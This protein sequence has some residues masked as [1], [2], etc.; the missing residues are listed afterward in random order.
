MADNSK[1]SNDEAKQLFKE[2][3]DRMKEAPEV[4]RCYDIFGTFTPQQ[5]STD[6]VDQFIGNL[7]RWYYG[8]DPY[9]EKRMTRGE[10]LQLSVMG[11]KS[12][13]PFRKGDLEVLNRFIKESRDRNKPNE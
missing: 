13:N 4:K 2:I 11:T 9:A 8:K 12:G 7:R 3:F 10:E 5:K 6:S 1:M